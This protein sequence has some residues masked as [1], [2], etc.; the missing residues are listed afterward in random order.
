M[1]RDAPSTSTTHLLHRVG[2]A[3]MSALLILSALPALGAPVAAANPLAITNVDTPDPV[4][5]SEQLLYT[6][7]IT[8][9]GGAKVSNA[10]LTDQING[11][12]GFGNPPLLDVVSSR[13]SCSQNNTQVTCNGG[14]IEGFGT[15]TVTVRGIVTA[16]TGTTINNIAT[17]TGTKSAQ[18][19]TSSAAATTQVTG[20]GPGGTSPDLT[21]G[22]NGPL[23]V[24]PGSDITYTL[25]INNIGTANATG[26]KVTDTV[27]AGITGLSATATSL[28]E[29][30]FAGQTLTCIN[31][32]VNAGANGTITINGTAPMVPGML[33]NTSVVDPDN[34]IDEGELGN[35]ADAAELNNQ[36]NTVLTEVS[37]LPPPPPGPITLDK[38]GPATAIPGEVID[39]TIVVQNGT[40]GRADYITVTDGTQGLQAASLQ[41]VSAVATSGTEPECV[42]AAPTVTCTMTRLAVDGTLTIVIRGMVV[43]SAGSSIVNTASVNANIKNDGYSASDEVQTIINPGIDLTITKADEPDPVCASSFPNFGTTDCRGGLAYT[44]AIGNSGIVGATDVVVRDPLPPGTTFDA[45]ASSPLCSEAGGVVTCVIP[46]IGPGATVLVTIVLVAPPEIG[47]IT[48]TVTVDPSNAIF[49]SDETNN[50]AVETTTVSTGIDLVIEKTDAPPGFDPIATSGTQTWTI[51]VDNLGTQDASGIRV[52]DTLPA[53][54]VF[55]DTEEDNGFTCTHSSGVVECIGG[56]IHGTHWETYLGNGSDSATITIVA[57]AQP[58]VGTMHNEVRVDPLNEIDEYDETN[59]LDFEDTTVTTGDGTIGAFNELSIA[60]SASPTTAGTSS[61]VTYTVV[62]TNSGTDP[63]VGVV[64]RDFLPSGFLFLS[65]E[66]SPLNPA[67]P[68]PFSCSHASGVV[69]CTGA[70]LDGTLN[71]LSSPDIPTTRTIVI[72]TLASPIPALNYVNTARVDPDNAIPEG[73][74]G[75]NFASASVNVTIISSQFIDLTVAKDDGIGMGEHAA[76][77]GLVSYTLT[78]ANGGTNPALNVA[79]RDSLPAGTTFVSAVDTTPAPNDGA[80]SCTHAAGVVTCSGAT[81]DGSDDL[82]GAGVPTQRVVT[83]IV[84][85]PIENTQITNQAVVDPNQTVAESN[86]TNNTSTVQTPVQSNID[87][88][89]DKTGPG[90][91]TQG[92]ESDYFITVRNLGTQDATNVLV[93]DPLPVGL[94]PLNVTVEEGDWTCEVFQNPV[95]LVECVGTLNAM[96]GDVDEVVIQIH[97][98]ITQ[99]GGTLDNEAC[100]DPDDTILEFSSNPDFNPDGNGNN[101]KTKVTAVVE[102]TPDM[103]V[104]KSAPGSVAPGE[105]LTYTIVAM[106]V[107]TAD[108][109]STTEVTDQLHADLTFVSAVASNDWTCSEASG[110]VSCTPPGTVAP[111]DLTLITIEATVSPSASSPIENTASVDATGDTNDANDHATVTT[112]VGGEGIDLVVASVSDSPDPVPHGDTLTYTAVVANAGSVEAQNVLVRATLLGI[113]TELDLAS[114]T[115]SQGFACS[116]VSAEPLS[117][118]IDC[119]GDLLP[120]QST[121]ITI[122]IQVNAGA[123]SPL[124]LDVVADPDD[125]IAEASELNNAGTEVTTLT[126]DICPTA[127][128]CIDLVMSTMLESADPIDVSETVTY[129]ITVGNIGNASTDTTMNDDVLIFFDVVGDVSGWSYTATNGFTCTDIPSAGQVLADCTGDLNAGNGTIIQITVT[130]DAAGSISATAFADPSSAYV[131]PGTIAELDESNNGPTSRFTTVNP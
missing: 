36:S 98:F 59:N 37:P 78:V 1:Y 65:A 5:S 63:A 52:R 45:A 122:V 102:P 95:N 94:I 129:T 40:L 62:V 110:L 10:V 97:V 23:A 101:C 57:F 103:Q 114:A 32:R 81:I 16:P 18:T 6:I 75:N 96:G 61:L 128:P 77:N 2:A 72:R 39:Y 117:S 12:V 42:V 131:G 118:P 4:A 76:P 68:H 107:G 30:S 9:T 49:E 29:C 67:D 85:A 15:W 127:D 55:L 28:F 120:G 58:F 126:G 34:T 51:T 130:A 80:F 7:Q 3:F 79:L 60:K 27:P 92:T 43:A 106:N 121:I 113:S 71:Q 86:E 66:E 31:G 111:G 50:I 46:S 33:E 26:I 25:T 48:N 87:L 54:A 53:G 13:G 74:E 11:V 104:T 125:T 83:I 89:L 69:E 17:V 119:S 41:V 88:E 64:V 22:K 73:N 109:P 14:T 93:R 105:S 44:F 115:A 108:A 19:F 112:S 21:I 84:R 35:T 56:S 116:P 82:A 24:T 123:G 8:N 99:N 90:E 91:V 47:E 38:Q 124:Q 70:T 100:V 20:S